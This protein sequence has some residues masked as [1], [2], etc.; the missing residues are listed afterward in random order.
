MHC[1]SLHT[2][3]LS[4]IV[5]RSKVAPNGQWDI[6]PAEDLLQKNN[7]IGCFYKQLIL[8]HKYVLKAKHL[9]WQCK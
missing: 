2:F 1:P 7:P 6:V 4:L 3:L 8:T 5:D 9:Y